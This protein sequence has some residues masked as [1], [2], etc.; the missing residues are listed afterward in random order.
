MKSDVAQYYK[1][2]M[3]KIDYQPVKQGIK[4]SM[5]PVESA[6]FVDDRSRRF[7]TSLLIETTSVMIVAVLAIKVFGINSALRAS[8]LTIPGILL[9]VALIPTVIKRREFPRFGL[10]IRHIRESLIVLG[11]TCVALL[12]LT[13]FGLWLLVSFGFELPLRPVM[14]QGQSW[15]HWLFYQFMYIALAEE[16]FFR[17]YVQN[18]ILRLTYPVMGNLPVFQQWISILISAAFFAVVHIIAK[19]QMISA[20]TF[21]PGLV[22]GWLFIRTGSL[23]APILF[24]GLANSCYLIMAAMLI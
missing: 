20:L 22:L 9:I 12:P 4:K 21:L 16:V 24:H 10:N 5:P 18:N 15:I 1:K 6:P 19:G 8:W 11:W 2:S 23:I 17:G 7:D 3:I 14:P 13:F